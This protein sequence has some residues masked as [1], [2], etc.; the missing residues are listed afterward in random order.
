MKTK[1]NQI[2]NS[3]IIEKNTARGASTKGHVCGNTVL[4]R[5]IRERLTD[6]FG[7]KI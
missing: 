6:H 1:I 4:T 2:S 3:V 5:V 7:A